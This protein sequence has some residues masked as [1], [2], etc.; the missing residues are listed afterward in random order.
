MGNIYRQEFRDRLNYG[1]SD[2]E[3][4]INLAS[5]ADLKKLEKKLEDWTRGYRDGKMYY[6]YKI[7]HSDTQYG[8]VRNNTYNLTLSTISGI[9]RPTP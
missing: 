4:M 7:K 3:L 6:T 5:Q 9:G 2:R 1:G 8:V